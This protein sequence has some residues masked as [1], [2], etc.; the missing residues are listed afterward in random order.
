MNNNKSVKMKNASRKARKQNIKQWFKKVLAFPIRAIKWLWRLI[1]RVCRAI[2]NWLKSIDIVGM[3]NLTLLVAIIVLFLSLISDFVRCNKCDKAVAS[4]NKS[5]IIMTQQKAKQPVDERRVVKR[6]Y[7]TVLPVKIDSQ[8]NI[9]PKIRTVGVAKPEI[10]RELSVPADELPQQTL[11]GDVIVEKYP[12]APVLS[13]GVKV[14]GN[15]YIQN[16]RKY[17]IPCDAKINGHLF[18]R[19]V[20]KVNFCGKFK[21]NGNVYVNRESS[22]GPLPEGTKINGQIIL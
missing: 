13:N 6:K 4:N 16:M 2:W 8:T 22:F 20:N 12:G 11:S 18:I 10:I 3:V 9:T 15:L 17:T 21:V 5:N 7:S 19:N 1:C 14:N